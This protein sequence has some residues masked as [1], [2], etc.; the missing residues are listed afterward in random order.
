[1]CT[2][3]SYIVGYH[4]AGDYYLEKQDFSKAIA[5][6][7]GADEPDLKGAEN[8]TNSIIQSENSSKKTEALKEVATVWMTTQAEG[9]KP[10]SSINKDSD[11]FT[12][13]QLFESPVATARS[14]RTSTIYEK[15]G[16]DVIRYA[17][18]VAE[19][20][21]MELLHNFN[22]D[23]FEVEIRQAL[24]IK[25]KDKPVDA[26][27]WYHSRNDNNRASIVA[28]NRITEFND[29]QMLS[30]IG[31]DLP[32]KGIPDE[33]ARRGIRF[34]TQLIKQCLK[35]AEKAN[36]ISMAKIDLA[37]LVTDKALDS[38]ELSEANASSLASVWMSFKNNPSIKIKLGA[39]NRRNKPH[40]KGVLFLNLLFQPN[41][42]TAIMRRNMMQWFGKKVVELVVSRNIS[43]KIEQYALLSEFDPNEFEH[44]RPQPKSTPK[45][46]INQEQNSR[47]GTN[48]TQPPSYDTGFKIGD[49]VV[50][51]DLKNRPE[52]NGRHGTI[53]EKTKEDRF[54]VKVEQE[55]K[56]FS[57][58]PEN[59]KRFASPPTEYNSSDE[60]PSQDSRN[61]N[62]SSSSSDT[63]DDDLSSGSSKGSRR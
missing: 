32:L 18:T 31:M 22:P 37:V 35:Q 19:K 11:T 9:L 14:S 63:S 16:R 38:I 20:A 12:F 5:L 41:D 1:M 17:F 34:Q 10:S 4:V 33:A 53:K 50:I 3:R 48:R 6:Y 60:L 59:L 27:Q 55:P 8:A 26:V 24:D 25:Y 51:K 7:L 42:S 49:T 52:L 15:F 23:A 29:E 44:L 62:A 30:V 45:Q 40:G 43:S 13:L 61:R 46:D 57:F 56:P 36:S 54:G 21:P 39:R 2:H 47:T 58:K 28:M